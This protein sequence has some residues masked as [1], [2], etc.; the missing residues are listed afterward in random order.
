MVLILWRMIRIWGENDASWNKSY[1]DLGMTP[2][3]G[4]CAN[5]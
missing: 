1:V 4:S 2:M 3:E 5:H